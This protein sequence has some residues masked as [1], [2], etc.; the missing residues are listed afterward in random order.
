MS[1]VF[2]YFVQTMRKQILSTNISKVGMDT[3]Y[4]LK[5]IEYYNAFTHV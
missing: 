2:S 5:S 1:D 4:E 3:G